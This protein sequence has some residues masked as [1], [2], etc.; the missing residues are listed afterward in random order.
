MAAPNDVQ[1][2]VLGK[3]AGY[4]VVL[5]FT[6]GELLIVPGDDYQLAKVIDTDGHVYGHLEYMSTREH[7][8]RARHRSAVQKRDPE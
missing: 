2:S 1:Q 4:R 6:T 7:R 3:F 5:Q 8:N